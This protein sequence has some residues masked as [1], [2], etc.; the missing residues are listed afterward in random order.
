MKKTGTIDTIK[1]D[2]DM[3]THAL[4]WIELNAD[5]TEY[6]VKKTRHLREEYELALATILKEKT[7]IENGAV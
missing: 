5:A 3:I 4:P 6:L 2:M 7:K 1:R